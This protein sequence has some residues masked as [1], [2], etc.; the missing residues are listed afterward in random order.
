LVGATEAA[1]IGAGSNF[2]PSNCAANGV[3]YSSSSSWNSSFFTYIAAGF[4]KS[5]G[6]INCPL[7]AFSIFLPS[8]S[9]FF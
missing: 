2:Y 7:A 6:G 4:F 3:L 8:N 1:E 9:C 5:S